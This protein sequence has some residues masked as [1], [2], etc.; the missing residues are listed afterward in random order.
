MVSPV[1]RARARLSNRA[2]IVG[3]SVSASVA[4]S[5]WSRVGEHGLSWRWRDLFDVEPTE[6]P[7]EFEDLELSQDPTLPA[8]ASVKLD[9]TTEQP[10]ARM[11]VHLTATVGTGVVADLDLYVLYDGNGDLR[12]R[13]SR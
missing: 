5:R 8:G 1:H 2:V 7:L 4:E 12:W 10:T 13:T 9:V 11:T 6:P 3:R